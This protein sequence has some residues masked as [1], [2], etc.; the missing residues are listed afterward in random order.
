MSLTFP[1]ILIVGIALFISIQVHSKPLR[2]HLSYYPTISAAGI[3]VAMERGWYKEAGVDLS[4]GFKNLSITE[5]V[6]SEEYDFGLH[7][8]HEIIRSVGAGKSVQAF[9]ADYQF[10]PLSIA[11][12]KEFKTLQDLKGRVIG[13]F[14]EQEKDFLKVIF[15]EAGLSLDDFRYVEVKEFGVDQLIRKFKRGEFDA[16]PVWEFNHPVGFALRGLNVRQF[17]S[18][19]YGFHFY[20]AVFFAR[21]KT[22]QQRSLEF[23]K[24]IEVTRRG[25]VEVYKN[26]EAAVSLVMSKWYPPAQY[27]NGSKELTRKQQM[28]QL[29][30]SKRYLY[31]GVGPANFGQ[32]TTFHWNA[33]LGVARTFG[34][35]KGRSVSISDVY[36]PDVLELVRQRKVRN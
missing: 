34:L 17:P 21:P 9:A 26:P 23:A 16:I 13:I 30:L 12:R 10:N 3:L 33:G 7:S 2:L 5:N 15:A 31:E 8:G 35:I 4:V 25:W 19:R 14:S 20:G 27:I 28:I 6:L 24:F 22:I 32:M 11:V 1:R 36:S 29:R 18:Y